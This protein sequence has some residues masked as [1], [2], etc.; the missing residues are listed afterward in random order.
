MI[1]RIKIGCKMVP[2]ITI[3]NTG[4]ESDRKEGTDQS[5]FACRVSGVC[6]THVE[7]PVKMCIPKHHTKALIFRGQ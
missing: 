5:L 4:G 1:P 7:R 2:V 3:G 6:V